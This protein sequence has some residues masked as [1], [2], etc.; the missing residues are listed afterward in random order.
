MKP[1]RYIDNT[2]KMLAKEAPYPKETRWIMWGAGILCVI[3][4]LTLAYG[5]RCIMQ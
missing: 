5:P 4:L 1:L 3:A 2:I